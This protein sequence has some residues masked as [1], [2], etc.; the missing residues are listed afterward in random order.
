MGDRGWVRVSVPSSEEDTL[1]NYY[2]H[3]GGGSLWETIK[4]AWERTQD[5]LPGHRYDV[6]DLFP[7][8][9]T[10]C[11]IANDGRMWMGECRSSPD[12]PWI[13]IRFL[14]GQKLPQ[15]QIYETHIINKDAWPWVEHDSLKWEGTLEDYLNLRG[16]GSWGSL[17]ED[18]R[19]VWPFMDE[20]PDPPDHLR[21]H[22]TI[23]K[24]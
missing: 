21:L 5:C 20:E 16:L 12:N 13:L 2:T 19:P 3:N 17:Q 1:F 7:M 23:L 10:G 18:E 15:V 9:L 22:K 11:F 6:P 24:E 14:P 4:N 8:I